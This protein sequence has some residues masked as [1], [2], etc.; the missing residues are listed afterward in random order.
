MKARFATGIALALL[1]CLFGARRASAD[2]FEATRAGAT[3][4]LKD[5]AKRGMKNGD[6]LNN[7][8]RIKYKDDPQQLA[9]WTV[10]SHLEKPPKK[11]VTP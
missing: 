4:G 6:K 8:V 10:A 1:I 11:K 5:A 9:A 7:I 2:T 3:G